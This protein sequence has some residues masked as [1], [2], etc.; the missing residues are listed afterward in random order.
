[1]S[2]FYDERRKDRAANRQADREDLRE[3]REQARKDADAQRRREAADQKAADEK[4][5]RIRR[6]RAE[7]RAKQLGWVKKNPVTL[8]VAFVMVCSIVPAV[9]SQ[10]G[11]LSGASVN[12][13]LAALLAAMLEGTAWA[14]TFMGHRAQ[15][16]G[17]STRKY[18]IGTWTTALLASAVNLWHGEQA[19]ATHRWVGLV[20]AASS[21]VAVFIWDL[22]TH[23]GHGPTKEE[24]QA[25]K[26]RAAHTK[27][28]AAHH[29][30]VLQVAE[31]LLSATPFGAL[32]GD[33][34]WRV[35]W[36]YVHGVEITGVTADLIAGQLKAQARITEVGPSR[37]VVELEPGM[38]P[39]PFLD[40]ETSV[41][42]TA[43]PEALEAASRPL[44]KSPE[45][46]GGKGLH[47]PE[48]A[49]AS[50]L[51]TVPGRGRNGRSTP[52]TSPGSATSPPCWRAPIR[53]SPPARSRS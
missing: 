13:G 6:E 53:R 28:R 47:A 11:A 19:Y 46:L 8:F 52:S 4:R 16:L 30:E 23:G 43:F 20:L 12:V 48:K 49:P 41:Y 1:M 36:S 39:D 38:P 24:R 32:A 31:R 45:S 3:Q 27:A 51:R 26:E 29:P 21:L 18:R 5:D 37:T 35:A 14:L 17:Q 22:H 34:A 40:D 15:T 33:D 44:P 50:P 7:K 10:V 25:V 9:I 42:R 2:G